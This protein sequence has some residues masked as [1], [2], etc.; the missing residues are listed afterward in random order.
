MKK[1]ISISA[2]LFLSFMVYGQK[3]VMTHTIKDNVV[4]QVA[5]TEQ[6]ITKNMVKTN[7]T[8]VHNGASVPVYA[9]KSGIHYAIIPVAGGIAKKRLMMN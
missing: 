8:Y 1:V 9:S 7:F 5:A 2:F 4:V 6:Q 3:P